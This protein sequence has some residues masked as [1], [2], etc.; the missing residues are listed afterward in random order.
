MLGVVKRKC[1]TDKDITHYN[2]L[3]EEKS[4]LEA[5]H[6]SSINKFRNS[7]TKLFPYCKQFIYKRGINTST[8]QLFKQ[9]YCIFQ[10]EWL[11]KRVYF[12]PLFL[13]RR[14]KT[15]V[16][17]EDISPSKLAGSKHQWLELKH[18]F[19]SGILFHVLR[20]FKI[21]ILK[22]EFFHG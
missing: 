22:A 15:A 19:S 17:V 16:A 21:F 10:N 12:Q 6:I 13:A 18:Y 14:E 1:K 4:Y 11:F 9:K 2:S 7:C 3:W 20:A 5:I 8:T